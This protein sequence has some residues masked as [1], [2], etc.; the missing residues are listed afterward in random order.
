M[1]ADCRWRAENPWAY[2]VVTVCT[3]RRIPTAT[4]KPTQPAM[5]ARDPDERCRRSDLWPEQCGHC[6]GGETP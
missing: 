2:D 6:R 5:P 1:C 3:N 4:R